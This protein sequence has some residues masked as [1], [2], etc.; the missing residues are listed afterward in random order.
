MTTRS[1]QILVIGA[2]A[3]GLGVAWD[4]C[5]RGLSVTVVEQG[6]LGQGTSGRYHGLLHSGGRY[7]LSDPT[8]AR[9]CRRENET[10][11]R[12]IPHAI[13]PTGG[14]FVGTEQDPPEYADRW[15]AACH[16]NGVPVEE[17]SA[18]AAL[19][20]EP[21]LTPRLARVFQVGDAALDSFELL[22]ALARGVTEAGGLVLTRHRVTGL[23][24]HG[25]GL[26]ARIVSCY[27]EASRSNRRRSSTPRP[28]AGRVAGMAGIHLPVALA[29]AR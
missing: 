24:P 5:L 15:V 23:V 3:T 1:S 29:K 14:Y 8:S 17:V 9:D 26:L 2:G 16:A 7:V 11:R 10:L 28:Y 22:H 21:L 13:E 6:D 19:Q 12:I 25:G 4:A 27:Q 20:R 18:S